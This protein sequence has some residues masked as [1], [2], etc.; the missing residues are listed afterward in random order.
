[1]NFGGP[2]VRDKLFFFLDYEGFRQTL[3]PLSVLTLPTQNELNG[4][5]V[6]PVQESCDGSCL[7][8][9]DTDSGR[10]IDPLSAQVVGYFKKIRKSAA[11]R[12]AGDDGAELERLLGGGAVHG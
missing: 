9:G 6:V 1:M 3:T 10:A 8:G 2:I 12:P 11:A 7:R 5:L 4:V